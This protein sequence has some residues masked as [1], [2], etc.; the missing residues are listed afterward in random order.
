M[1]IPGKYVFLCCSVF[2]SVCG[3]DLSLRLLDTQGKTITQVAQ[4]VPFVLSVIARGHAGM[5]GEPAID[6]ADQLS[7]FQRQPVVASMSFVNGVQS[8]SKKYSFMARID[9]CGSYALGPARIVDG[10]RLIR[11]N[12]LVF[13]V[14]KASSEQ[15]K[16]ALLLLVQPNKTT[17]YV[18][19]QL[20]LDVRICWQDRVKQAALEQCVLPRAAVYV[21]G[22]P[23][24]ERYE[25]QKKIWQ[26]VHYVLVVYPKKSG[27]LLIPRL[28]AQC[29][30]ERE[31]QSFFA[32][33]FGPSLERTFVHSQPIAVNVRALPEP[34]VTIDGV[35]SFQNFQM[36]VDHA[37]T[38]QSEA[39]TVTLSITSDGDAA[40]LLTGLRGIGDAVR[41][42]ESATH[43]QFDHGKRGF[44]TKKREWVVQALC[45]GIITIPAQTFAYF[46]PQRARYETLR[47]EPIVVTVRAD[48][49]PVSGAST[50]AKR[51]LRVPAIPLEWFFVLLFLGIA[52]LLVGYV[53][54]SWKLMP[55]HF[56]Y[57]ALKRMVERGVKKHD[58]I[59]VYDAWLLFFADY[60]HTTIEQMSLK[61]M[62]DFGEKM[63]N[64]K[65]LIDQW[66]RYAMRLESAAFDREHATTHEA[67]GDESVLW[68]RKVKKCL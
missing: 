32:H 23:E 61:K 44:F 62:V 10:N 39:V 42:Y 15:E 16:S 20:L 34:K 31:E 63:F 33:F 11:S 12:A 8:V 59:T 45:S 13:D 30:V 3:N 22:Q 46:D 28:T 65:Q 24:Q 5:L 7:V 18:G 2:L 67:L 41:L 60:E 36:T 37:D 51:L 19:E 27:E 35:G 47:T 58:Y 38:R 17:V 25:Y 56:G 1:C 49:M 52:G 57:R 53:W 40:N 26:C 54:Q 64:N 55:A 4:G 6:H 66:K 21:L 43:V 9:H 29:Q 48:K 14:V 68:L 50:V